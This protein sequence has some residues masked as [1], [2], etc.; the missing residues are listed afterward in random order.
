MNANTL[1]LRLE[2]PM[3][4]WGN[5]E[6][7]FVIRRT[8]EAPTKSGVIGMLCAALGVSR[9]Q[10]AEKWL[11]KLNALR[12]G[13]RT[14]VP[15]VRWWDYHTI[16]AGMQMRIAEGDGKTKPG[17]LL[18][19]RE[20]LCDASYLVALMGEPT[21][22]AELKEAIKAPRWTLYLGKKSCIPSRPLLEHPPG[23]FPDLIS[24]LASVP[25]RKRLK[26]DKK[27]HFL[28]CLLDWEPTPEQPEAPDDALVWFDVPCSFEPPVHRPR[29]V[30]RKQ[31]SL[32]NDV[33]IAELPASSKTP[34]RPRPRADYN[35]TEYKKARSARLDADHGLCV[36]CKS[37]AV[38]TH[39]IT[40]RRAGGYEAH[41]DLRS[42]CRLCHDAVTMIEYGLGRSL[43]RINPE[44]PHWKGEIN[45]KRAEIVKFRSLETR[46]RHFGAEFAEEV[47]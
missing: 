21:I 14:D 34:P 30:V 2:G 15:G 4:A 6:S 3:Q 36:F 24:A 43:D 8:A 12:M 20:Y 17:A 28:N 37:P 27:T 44:E 35:N 13:V 29:F 38:T 22:I 9:Q 26:E 40:Y 1:F 33:D 11:P 42:L 31:L 19:R 25:W 5:Q 16:G 46:R 10:A 47:E 23:E 39:H 32:G 45:K 18:T 7:K 41:E